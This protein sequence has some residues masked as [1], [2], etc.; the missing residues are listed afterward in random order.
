[1][2]IDELK[3]NQPFQEK[4]GGLSFLLTSC[5]AETDDNQLLY[6][7]IDYCDD[8]ECTNE[9]PHAIRR[10]ESERP[11]SDEFLVNLSKLAGPTISFVQNNNVIFLK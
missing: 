1:M 3:K 10:I 7:I 11:M 9:F 2:D 4:L 5:I 8:E 6:V